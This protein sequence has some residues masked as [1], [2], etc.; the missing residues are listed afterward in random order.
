MTI[1]EHKRSPSPYLALSLLVLLVFGAS[2]QNSFVWDDYSMVVDNPGIA[3]PFKDIPSVFMSPLHKFTGS[4]EKNQAYYRPVVL[5][6][7]MLIHKICGLDPF[8]FHLAD[9]IL[10]LMTVL[11][12]YKVGLLIFGGDGITP[13][14]GAALFA[15]HP[16]NTEAVVW[17]SSCEVIC[18]FFIVI[19][20]YFFLAERKPLSLAAFCLSLLS[21]EMAV[22]FPFALFLLSAGMKGLRKGVKDIAPYMVFSGLYFAI[23]F[24]VLDSV[25]GRLADSPLPVRLATMAVAYADYVRLLFLPYPLSIFHPARWYSFSDPR[26]LAALLMLFAVV[27]AAFRLRSSGALLFLVGMPFIMLAPVVFN[28]NSLA[29]GNAGVSIAERY[30]YI[31]AMA[32]SLLAAFSLRRLFQGRD[33][34]YLLACYAA[35]LVLFASMTVSYSLSWRSDLTLFSRVADEFP[36]IAIFHHNLGFAYEK[37]GRLDDAANEYKTAARLKPDYGLT[38]NNLGH[39]YF[40][41]GRLEDAL[42][43]Y[44]LA[45]RIDPENLFA[46]R[47]IANTYMKLG[48]TDLAIVHYLR[49]L[50][51]N[52][53]HADIHN[54]LGVAYKRKGMMEDA[55][56][57]FMAAEAI[58]PGL[59]QARQNREVMGDAKGASI[60]GSHAGGRQ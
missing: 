7:F 48:F 17:I 8:G 3:L 53:A 16:V 55:R 15:V 54:N 29:I 51:L 9:I 25:L 24:L 42:E 21:L 40:K 12:L 34:K 46:N 20:L 47:N 23:R 57:E 60:N 30:L 43:E 18:G 36:D 2:L 56:R 11:M 10:H 13:L 41:Q 22:M 28:V 14:A 58:N 45:L 37:I 59:Y 35:V 39:V 19:S 4:T 49:I 38:H 44:R 50:R 1:F 26:V 31:P 52:P 32:F 6:F 33:I 27:M 5:L